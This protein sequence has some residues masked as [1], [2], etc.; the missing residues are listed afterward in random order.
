MR[1][2]PTRGLGSILMSNATNLRAWS[3]LDEADRL[4]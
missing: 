1:L 2:S 4:I 3:C